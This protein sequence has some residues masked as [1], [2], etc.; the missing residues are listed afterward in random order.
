MERCGDII[1]LDDDVQEQGPL[2][3]S[4]QVAVAQGQAHLLIN[5]A[6]ILAQVGSPVL[7]KQRRAL[8]ERL[9]WLCVFGDSE[10]KEQ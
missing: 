8:G 3:S 5:T 1:I 2:P 6:D 10:V 4:M 7:A 9:L